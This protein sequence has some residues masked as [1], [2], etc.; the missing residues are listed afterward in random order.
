LPL[1]NS[2]GIQ[3][4]ASYIV[5]NIVMVSFFDRKTPAHRDMLVPLQQAESA[6][7]ARGITPP[8]DTFYSFVPREMKGRTNKLSKHAVGRAF[9]INH[10]HNVYIAD[11]RD[12]RVIQAVTGVDLNLKL[13]KSPEV[14]RNASVTFQE[15]F[16]QQWI[17]QLQQWADRRDTQLLLKAIRECRQSLDSYAKNR[18][19]PWRNGVRKT[20]PKR[21]FF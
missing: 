5:A 19:S 11:Q 7:R 4:P 1:Y 17:D 12:I 9:D 18:V 6:L 3:N 8:I 14:M 10:Q 13:G 16:N 21:P 15:R 20:S 2:I